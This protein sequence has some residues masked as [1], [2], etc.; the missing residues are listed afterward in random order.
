MPYQTVPVDA[1]L[2]LS[3]AG[4]YIYHT[5]KD[6]D[7]EQGPN[8]FWFTTQRVDCDDQYMFDVRDLDSAHLLEQHPPY[9]QGENDTPENRAAWQRWHEVD[10][11]D[12]IQAIIRASID[13]GLIKAPEADE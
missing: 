5:Y 3:Q 4:V 9:L 6:D 1:E 13:A 12:A 11:P 10:E 2:F 7:I 8:Q